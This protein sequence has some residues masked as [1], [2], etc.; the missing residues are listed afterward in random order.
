MPRDICLDTGPISLFYSKKPPNEISSLLKN[1]KQKKV[2]AHV[3]WP[4][5]IEVYKN[6][7]ILKGKAYAEST[8]A[9][10]MN[11][12]PIIL[13]DMDLSLILKAGALKCQY[14][15]ILSYNDCLVIAYS[16]NKKMTLHTT[17]K[18]LPKIPNLFVKKYKF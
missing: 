12:Y 8:I 11:N 9:S 17:E 13:V 4:I 16:L 18:D 2:K 3:I 7:C 6:L 10:L 15:N 1:I 14:R 5:L